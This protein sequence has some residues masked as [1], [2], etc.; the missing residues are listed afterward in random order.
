MSQA[1]ASTEE[2]AIFPTSRC[3]G[4]LK[5]LLYRNERVTEM[6]INPTTNLNI[7]SV[8]LATT[9]PALVTLYHNKVS[10][11]FILWL[12]E[13]Q[14]LLLIWSKKRNT[15]SHLRVKGSTPS[16]K[17][18]YNEGTEWIQEHEAPRPTEQELRGG[19]ALVQLNLKLR[20]CP[21]VTAANSGCSGRAGR[22]RLN[23]SPSYS[24]FTRCQRET[25]SSWLMSSLSSG[26]S[27]FLQFGARSLVM[28]WVTA[29]TYWY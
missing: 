5:L 9:S 25:S 26:D 18:F 17:F 4:K 20:P 24:P 1:S 7:F 19:V 21:S 14:L 12:L 13:N 29:G 3:F 15:A 6:A 22:R 2:S 28:R 11:S 23:V 10:R 27:L 8:M 16:L